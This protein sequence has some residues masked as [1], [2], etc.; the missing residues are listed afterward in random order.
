MRWLRSPG[1]FLYSLLLVFLVLVF[2]PQLSSQEIIIS[3]TM[4]NGFK[5]EY[6]QLVKH[7]ESLSAS[8]DN[9]ALII[10]ELKE[11]SGEQ[12][13]KLNWTLNELAT[14]NAKLK[15][16]ETQADSLG[17]LLEESENSLT[18]LTGSMKKEKIK[19]VLIGGGVGLIVG[20]VVTGLIIG[21]N[22]G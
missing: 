16:A 9:S 14:L 8:L 15:K 7:N 18:K 13:I 22:N 5:L 6:A 10:S 12:L 4:W 11:S 21:L 17:S 2:T 19:M 20:A 1:G 3:E